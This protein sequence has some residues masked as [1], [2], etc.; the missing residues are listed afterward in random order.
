MTAARAHF[1][2]F[3]ADDP[4]ALARDIA[5]AQDDLAALRAG[6]DEGKV[7]DAIAPLGSLLTTA[8]REEEAVA[9]LEPAVTRARVDGGGEPLGWLLLSL[10]TANQ[11]LGRT[12]HA[13]EQF[14]EA[15]A[16]AE[17]LNA[18]HLLHMTLAHRGRFLVEQ[19]KLQEARRC[20]ERSLDLRVRTKHP[21]Q[22]S[23]RRL[24]DA[25]ALLEAARGD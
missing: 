1:H 12:Q 24:L 21:K 16:L 22:A 13:R 5:A 6:G 7:L 14:A 15:Q 9:L 2:R 19:G 23:I 18:E 3:T 10:A 11:Y 17:S 8:R 4:L 25:L 20:F